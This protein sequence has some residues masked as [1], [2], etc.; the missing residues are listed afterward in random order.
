MVAAVR[1]RTPAAV[2]DEDVLPLLF[3]WLIALSAGAAWLVVVYLA[4]APAMQPRPTA[5]PS[6]PVIGFDP[7]AAPRS[8]QRILEPGA[9]PSTA[10]GHAHTKAAHSALDVAEAFVT[11]AAAGVVDHLSQL[12]PGAIAVHG[13]IGSAATGQT[14]LSATGSE[15]T[16][17]MAQL[18]HGNATN[19][20][21]G[22]V[23][24][25]GAIARSNVQVQPL[26]IVRAAPLGAETA[27][28]T[29]MGAFVRGRVAQL[30]TCYERAGGTDLAG[31]VALR[32]TMGAGGAVR[33]ADI[34]RRSWSGP[35]A[36]ATE[37]CL[38]DIVKGWRMPFA[39]DGSSI[40]IPISFTRGA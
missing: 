8:T 20:S 25:G 29:E 26:P 3:S 39:P 33:T 38:L 32:V 37:A 1:L 21:V 35:G 13:E 7:D 34:V 2:R 19:G 6:A 11:T 24:H 10:S 22:A 16:P 27:D 15:A 5:V 23:Q 17:G 30:Q 31:I 28:A 14:T 9:A 40:T 12:I 18:S 4:P 36:A